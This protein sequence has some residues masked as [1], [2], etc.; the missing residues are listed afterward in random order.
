MAKTKL[1][2]KSLEDYHRY[3]N[4]KFIN[5]MINDDEC[6]E[7]VEHTLEL[8]GSWS[9]DYTESNTSQNYLE[10]SC[11]PS[12]LAK[13]TKALETFVEDLKL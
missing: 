13:A 12:D 7:D 11:E 8:E 9:V 1:G 2:I 10:F 6:F 5:F 3:Y 4:D